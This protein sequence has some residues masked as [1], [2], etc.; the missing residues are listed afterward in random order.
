MARP[1]EF[2]VDS[3]L[4]EAMNLF[5]VQGYKATS[6]QA[7][8]DVMGI[9]KSSFYATFGSKHKLFL[10]SIKVYAK[11]TTQTL[12]DRL[13][14][15]GSF[16]AAVDDIINTVVED[17]LSH[18]GRR[19]C[20]LANSAIELSPHDSRVERLIAT[21]IKRVENAF[22]TAI[23]QA[24]QR[25]ELGKSKDARALARFVVCNLNG[26]MVIGKATPE[27][28]TLLDIKNVVISALR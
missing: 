1:C 13:D 10:A 20:M 22:F 16:I 4:H 5:W 28:A 9:S 3:V 2:D 21:E 11:C 27:R 8:L 7:L 15:P 14:E 18:D 23:G 19:G 12:I 24:Q 25:G 6:L 17:T 26:L